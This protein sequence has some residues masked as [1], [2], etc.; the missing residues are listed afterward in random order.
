MMGLRLV[1][2]VLASLSS[3]VRP[4][5]PPTAL[6]ARSKALS[7][8]TRRFESNSGAPQGEGSSGAA[9]RSG[10]NNN[11]NNRSRN[12]NNGNNRNG[13]NNRRNNGPGNGNRRR[14]GG[15]G[16]GVLKLESPLLLVR[17]NDIEELQ[18]RR[19]EAAERRQNNRGNYN[20]RGGGGGGG[21]NQAAASGPDKTVMSFTV[22]SNDVTVT[23]QQRPSPPGR[24]NQRR[25]GRGV[26]GGPGSDGPRRRGPGGPRMNRQSNPRLRRGSLKKRRKKEKKKVIEPPVIIAE[27]ALSVGD[28]AAKLDAKA[29]EVVKYLMMNLGVL[30]SVSQSVDQATAVSV[31]EGFGKKAVTS[32][33]E[34][35][36]YMAGMGAEDAEDDEFDED[37]EDEDEDDED[38]YEEVDEVAELVGSGIGFEADDEADLEPRPPVVT[39]MGHVDHGKTTLLDAIRNARVASGE[40][41]GITQHIGA[42]QVATESGKPVTFIDTPGH[43]AFNTMR[44]RGANVTDIVILVVAADD[45]VKEQTIESIGCAKRAGVPIIV[46]VNKIDKEAADPS[47]VSTELTG[48]DLV[49]EDYGGDVL[50]SQISAK[51]KVGLDDLLEKVIMQADLL[52]L[53]ANPNADARGTVVEAEVE[54][55]LGTVA[56]M[57]VQRGTLRVGDTFVAGASSGKVRA[58]IDPATKKR[59]KTAV[60]GDPVRV[61]GFEGVPEA[62]DVLAVC[63]SQ[64]AARAAAEAR[65]RLARDAEARERGD[66]LRTSVT[67]MLTGGE[68]DLR[69]RKDV[70]VLV[71]ADVQ[72]SVEALQQALEGLEASNKAAV[73]SP[74]VINAGVGDVTMS[75]VAMAAVGDSPAQILAFGVAANPQAMDEARR[76]GVDIKY[77]GIVYEIL[78]DM[79]KKLEEVLSPKPEGVYSGRAVV[80]Q[81]FE[82]GKLGKIAG[83]ECVDGK[84]VKGSNVRV[85]RNDEIMHFGEIT[86]LK[87][88]KA[89]V[90][91]VP[92]GTECGIGLDWE[93]MQEGDVI[94]SY[95]DE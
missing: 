20:R 68:I 29:P 65:T 26:E 83:S 47:R 93:D 30:A 45:G 55:G 41:G 13:N 69:E 36:A 53:K 58:I 81:I 42:Y 3:F 60:P 51:N 73:C 24:G 62:G 16:G 79:E 22:T 67:A 33:A 11:G 63:D 64:E 89:D 28:L 52:D 87:N 6:P 94:E 46:A 84:V 39:I 38:A 85:L 49:L 2:L 5:V 48:Y 71:K 75:D 77:A 59:V 74:R 44:S 34:A 8:Q 23:Q 7:L 56:T 72:G 95:L 76:L 91:E 57:L 9:V 90:T 78:E 50:S 66:A 31:V 35:E 4:F 92:A 40:K 27:A 70:P 10:N 32:E 17:I 14:G 37:D 82:I 15:G 19:A 88:L 86:T 61:V 18:D 25:R 21:N 1:L 43:A 12:N 80:K 54:R